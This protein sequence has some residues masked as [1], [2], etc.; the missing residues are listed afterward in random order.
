[1]AVSV[2]QIQSDYDA[3]VRRFA[4]P[5]ATVRD[6]AQGLV[7]RAGIPGMPTSYLIDRRGR[8]RSVHEGFHSGET[9]PAL[10]R[11]IEGLLSEK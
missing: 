4:P 7:A 2:D 9:E 5:F 6:Q 11:E 3:F 8:V 10:R 1:V